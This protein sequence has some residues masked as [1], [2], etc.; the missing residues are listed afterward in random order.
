MK[1]IYLSRRNKRKITDRTPEKVTENK[2]A[3]TDESVAKADDHPEEVTETIKEMERNK[4]TSNEPESDT[5]I[6]AK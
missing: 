3:N 4:G 6:K 1:V 5:S 2:Q